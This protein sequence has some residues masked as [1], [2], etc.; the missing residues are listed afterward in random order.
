[1]ARRARAAGAFIGMAHPHASLLTLADAESLDAAHSVEIYNVLAE[2]ERRSDSLHLYDTL[3]SRGHRL[4]AYAADDAHFRSWTPPPCRAWVNVRAT[5]PEPTSLLAALRAGHF[6]PSTGPEIH[7]IGLKAGTVTVECSAAAAVMI[8]G[9]VPG[10]QI[11][12]GDGLS[13]CSLPLAQFEE[14]SYVRVTVVDGSD[15][16]AWSQPIWL[17]RA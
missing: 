5:S 17:D 8:T 16:R 3:L 4:T 13:S 14:S 2:M 6:Y 15:A 12:T 1:M 10:Y 9:A 11:V 7:S